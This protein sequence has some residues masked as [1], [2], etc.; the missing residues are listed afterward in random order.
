MATTRRSLPIRL[1]A[2][3]GVLALLLTACPR[4]E[5]APPPDDDG[6]AIGEDEPDP[7]ADTGESTLDVVRDRGNL[8]CGV[9]D[10]LVGFG[11]QTEEGDF[12]GFD[13][14]F[15]RAV[16]AAVLGDADAVE[17]VPLTAE[18]RFTALQADEI[19]VLIRNTTWTATRDGGEGATFATTTFYDGQGMMVEADSGITELEDLEGGSVCVLSGTTTE[20]NLESIFSA[21]GIDYEPLTF[22]DND[23]LREA[24]LAGRCDGW[25]SDK[26]QLTS[27]QDAW[28]EEE[29]GPEALT[30]LDETMSKEPLGP[31]TRDGDQRWSD[32]VNWVVIATIEAEELDITSENI[33]D[34]MDVDPEEEPRMARFLGI[35]DFDPGLDLP[36]DF[37]E[38]IIRQVGNYG[39]IYDRHVGADGLG[40]ERGLND[41]WINGGLL[42]APPYG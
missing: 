28:P 21:R 15:C 36:A 18:A 10:V 35:A 17:Y 31:A 40:L 42:Y 26:S 4:D 9:N 29:G 25:T 24:F 6:E 41:L 12:E 3:L 22:E 16:A 34:F 30:I 38:Q 32:A 37:A 7:Q 20:L 23:T 11:F 1:L 14:D 8:I 13:I 5:D 19:D 33:D 2:L 27:F 39:E